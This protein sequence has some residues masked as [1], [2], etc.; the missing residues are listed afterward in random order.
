MR[1]N[2]WNCSKFAQWVRSTFGSYVKPNSA[3]GEQWNEWKVFNKAEHPFIFWF[4]EDFL[5]ALQDVIYW[6]YDKIMNVKYYL[7]N[8]FVSKTHVLRTRLKFGQYCEID[9]RMLHGMFETLIDFIECEKAHMGTWNHP[10][11]KSIN[12]WYKEWRCPEAG[13]SVLNWE[14]TLYKPQKDEEGNEI[15]YSESP[16]QAASACEQLELYNWWKYI[17]PD[18]P[19]P[20]ETVTGKGSARYDKINQITEQYNKE[21]EEMLIRL[22]KIRSHLWT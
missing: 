4:T 8:G 15:P 6:P 11:F 3:T 16:R 21:D 5:I 18:R 7:I 17:R 22:I 2:Y 1:S 9:D 14:M 12:P 13:I 20:Y 10:E 19:D